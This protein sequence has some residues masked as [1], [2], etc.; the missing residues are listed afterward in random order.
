LQDHYFKD[1]AV[2][3]ERYFLRRFLGLDDPLCRSV[4]LWGSEKDI[5]E[6]GIG[7]KARLT[8]WW[9]Q[10]T[11]LNTFRIGEESLQHYAETINS[12]RPVLIKG[13]AGSLYQ[14][15]RFAKRKNLR[16]H[17]PKVI[18]SSAESLRGFMRDEIEQVFDRKV[19]DFYGSREVGP[20]AGEC[21]KGKM[22]VFN[23]H[24][25]VEVVN[26]KNEATRVNE[27]GRVLVSSLHNYSM[28]LIRYE[29]GDTAVP[30]NPCE[31]GIESGTL[32][33]VTGR[34]T[35]HFL[36]KDGG[37][38]HGEY[39]THLFYFVDWVDEFQIVQH[40]C[41]EV[42]L[43]YVA[44]GKHEPRVVQEIDDKIRLVMGNDCHVKWTEVSE[45]PR[46][47]HGK[48]LFTRSEIAEAK[49]R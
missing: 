46:T 3:S 13:Y 20:I 19:Y 49:W 43:F 7:L 18:Y 34:I 32:E 14:L 1:W 6:R 37:L 8:N 40:T 2:A 41:D 16:L 44:S 22:H 27:E 42:E 31:C 45:I 23:F 35:D 48:Q 12:I 26:A 30:G 39:F 36:R 33:Q 15:A 21:A 28:P 38:V 17:K 10:T 4:V 47:P 9:T 29:I 25:Y 5:F 24:N 11:F